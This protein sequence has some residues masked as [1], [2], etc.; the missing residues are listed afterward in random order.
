[1]SPLAVGENYQRRPR[2]GYPIHVELTRLPG[3]F[4]NK[5]CFPADANGDRIVYQG[6]V[7]AQVT[8]GLYASGMTPGQTYYV[9]YAADAGYGTGSDTAVGILAEIH[10]ATVTDWQVAPVDRG[11]AYEKRCYEG[12]GPIGVVS[13]LAKAGLSDIKW[14]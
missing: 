8:G 7:L 12:G 1:M 4:L 3:G 13:A 11:T 14:R 9:P 5:E 10:D 6:L 2:G